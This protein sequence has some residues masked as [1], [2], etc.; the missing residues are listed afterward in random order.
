MKVAQL[1]K[2]QGLELYTFGLKLIFIY[3]EYGGPTLFASLMNFCITKVLERL[4]AYQSTLQL[5]GKNGPVLFK[6]RHVS[7]IIVRLKIGQVN[8]SP[9]NKASIS[10]LALCKPLFTYPVAGYKLRHTVQ[11]NH[12]RVRVL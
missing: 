3:A 5:V 8:L 7:A 9:L 2:Q 11:L 4:R 12:K 10:A 6:T 1:L